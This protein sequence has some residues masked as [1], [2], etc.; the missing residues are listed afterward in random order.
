MR[1]I[2][3]ELIAIPSDKYELNVIIDFA[4]STVE[5]Q[6]A[7][8][9]MVKISKKKYQHAGPLYLPMNSAYCSTMA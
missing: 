5:E 8:L 2:G 9:I 3:A 7:I 1:A 4:N 6:T